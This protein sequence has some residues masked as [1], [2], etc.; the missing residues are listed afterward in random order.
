MEYNIR[1]ENEVLI[2][3]FIIMNRKVLLCEMVLNFCF[4]WM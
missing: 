3:F 2:N 4:L 1:C